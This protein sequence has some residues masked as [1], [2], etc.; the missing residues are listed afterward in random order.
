MSNQKPI[1]KVT[2]KD[3]NRSGITII[4]NSQKQKIDND[5]NKEYKNYEDESSS[6]NFSDYDQNDKFS[7]NAFESPVS[8]NLNIFKQVLNL[9]WGILFKLLFNPLYVY[10]IVLSSFCYYVGD[11]LIS[12]LI[13]LNLFLLSLAKST[14]SK[15][16]SNKVRLD[17]KF[18]VVRDNKIIFVPNYQI[19]I[20]DIIKLQRGDTNPVDIIIEDANCLRVNELVNFETFKEVSKVTNDALTAGSIVLEGSLIGEVFAIGNDRKY[21][22]EEIYSVNDGKFNNLIHNYNFVSILIQIFIILVIIGGYFVGTTYFPSF[23]LFHLI[24]L[25]SSILIFYYENALFTLKQLISFEFKNSLQSNAI[26]FINENKT[27]NQ[28]IE[29]ILIDFEYFYNLKSKNHIDTIHISPFL[30]NISSN[31]PDY[32]KIGTLEHS[33]F[34]TNQENKQNSLSLKPSFKIG[35]FIKYQPFDY[36]TKLT[37]YIFEYGELIV[38]ESKEIVNTLRL[39][40]FSK[41]EILGDISLL[42]IKCKLGQS[43]GW[44]SSED[45]SRH[46]LGSA[47]YKVLIP[48]EYYEIDNNTKIISPH[49]KEFTQSVLRQLVPDLT[50][51]SY[52]NLY[53]LDTSNNTILKKQLNYYTVF[54]N[55]KES[56]CN[57]LLNSYPSASLS[58]V[59]YFKNQNVL[60]V[61]SISRTLVSINESDIYL[62]N[63]DIKSLLSLVRGFNSFFGNNLNY[64]NTIFLVVATSIISV[65][66]FPFSFL[67]PN[68]SLYLLSLSSFTLLL[69][70]IFNLKSNNIN[71]LK[72]LTWLICLLIFKLVPTITSQYIPAL[73]TIVLLSYILDLFDL[74]LVIK[75]LLI[76]IFAYI[77]IFLFPLVNLTFIA[78]SIFLIVIINLFIDNI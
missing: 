15:S 10:L 26:T 46:Y 3:I 45:Y 71:P 1:I 43:F 42:E 50:S 68:S 24:L 54:Y 57:I 21:I 27:L 34:K 20:G 9:F 18:N 11:Y 70:T 33:I 7:K 6:S 38:G 41:L 32:I 23:N 74:N 19:K 51:S 61:A 64:I 29:N 12:F 69:Y 65:A 2:S 17:I 35:K 47:F 56:N 39:D 76:A 14:K 16:N 48:D 40:E 13:F 31:I 63:T 28:K 77:L 30:Y 73:T 75:F 5:I 59:E 52:L 44:I 49:S 36:R 58:S 25:C 53:D 66:I 55:A 4:P 72:I 62:P 78:I 37:S 67:N 60:S 8:K 22:L